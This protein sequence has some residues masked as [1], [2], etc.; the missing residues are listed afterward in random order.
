[1]WFS[2]LD[3]ELIAVSFGAVLLF[4]KMIYKKHL[5]VQ[6][7]KVG[8]IIIFS[9]RISE[10]GQE[11]MSRLIF[12]FFFH[13]DSEQPR[14]L[15]LF[16][17]RIRN[18]FTGVDEITRVQTSR[19]KLNHTPRIVNFFKGKNDSLS[20]LKIHKRWAALKITLYSHVMFVKVPTIVITKYWH[21]P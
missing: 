20:Y 6:W 2:P 13:R 9:S 14:Q 1:M 8:T 18:W 15:I 4:S 7:N 5:K 11:R 21:L 10:K 12:N 3:T 17:F 16:S 19:K